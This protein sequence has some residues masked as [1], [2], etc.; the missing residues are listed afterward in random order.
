V[1]NVKVGYIWES[2][3]T[4]DLELDITTDP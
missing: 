1:A 2:M 3:I 4:K